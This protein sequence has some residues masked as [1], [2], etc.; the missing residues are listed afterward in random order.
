MTKFIG[1]II[2]YIEV[3]FGKLWVVMNFGPMEV[4]LN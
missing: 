3:I 1:L 4:W 2:N